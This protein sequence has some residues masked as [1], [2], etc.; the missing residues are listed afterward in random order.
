MTNQFSLSIENG[1]TVE[2]NG[3]HVEGKSFIA[4]NVLAYPKTLRSVMRKY[5][6]RQK[7]KKAYLL[8]GM[9]L[10]CLNSVVKLII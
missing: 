5:T 9:N 6:E 8:A 10:H 3:D 1:L 7:S 4:A 2:E